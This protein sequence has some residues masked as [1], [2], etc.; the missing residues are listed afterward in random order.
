MVF[1][2][3][4]L[5]P[6]LFFD[7]ASRLPTPHMKACITGDHDSNARLEAEFQR[8]N[9]NAEFERRN[10]MKRYLDRLVKFMDSELNETVAAACERWRRFDSIGG[11][12]LLLFMLEVNAFE[13]AFQFGDAPEIRDHLTVDLLKVNAQIINLERSGNEV[14]STYNRVLVLMREKET[15]AKTKTRLY[16]DA[17]VLFSKSVQKYNVD[18]DRESCLESSKDGFSKLFLFLADVTD[19]FKFM[20]YGNKM[21]EK[22]EEIQFLHL[23]YYRDLAVKSIL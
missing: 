20:G 1:P 18:G 10:E 22:M 2:F 13:A 3:E 8:R 14:V 19:I 9:L 23:C 17:K 11:F 4:K 12:D 15:L 6:D 7:V 21:N 5:P 16:R